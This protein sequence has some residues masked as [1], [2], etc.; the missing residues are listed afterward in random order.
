MK[1][2]TI[3][4]SASVLLTIIVDSATGVGLLR[5]PLF[6][7]FLCIIFLIKLLVNGYLTQNQIVLY[8]PEYFLGLRLGSIP[9]EDFL[10]GFSMV[11]MSVIFWELFK[12]RRQRSVQR[13]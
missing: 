2:Y 3:I 8:N 9:F 13:R 7:L 11:T 10:F 4:S 5:R 1:E 12:E 6:Y